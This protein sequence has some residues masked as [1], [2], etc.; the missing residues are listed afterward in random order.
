MIEYWQGSKYNPR[1]WQYEALPK[2]IE[3]LKNGQRPIVAATMGAGKSVVIAELCWVALH[4]LKQTQKIIIAAPRQHL[5]EQLADTVGKRIGHEKVG[6]FY[7]HA[8]E[9]SPPVIVCCYASAKKLSH[10]LD[11]FRCVLL[12]GDEVHGTESDHFKT[13]Y[14]NIAPLCSVGFTATP[15]RSETNKTLSLWDSIAY[16]YTAKEALE[17]GVIVPWKLVHWDGGTFNKNQVDEICLDLIS[18]NGVGPGIVN[19]SSI[20]DCEAFAD[21]LKKRGYKAESVH[22]GMTKDEQILYIDRLRLG[23]LDILVHVNMLSE[24]VDFPFL[25]WLCMRRP[26]GAKV[27]FVQEVGRVLRSDVGKTEAIIMDPFD[28]FSQHGLI[29]PEQIGKL[30]IN[31]PDDELLAKL[32]LE[33]NDEIVEEFKN[34][35]PAV[36]INNCESWITGMITTMRVNGLAKPPNPD[37][38]RLRNEPPT[39]RQIKTLSRLKWAT[40][41]LP[42]THRDDFKLFFEEE[43]LLRLSQGAVS[44][45]LDICFSLAALSTSQRK[46]HRHWNFPESVKLP[47]TKIPIQGLL[48]ITNR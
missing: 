3:C 9:I 36:A 5:V 12:I 25:R 26:V 21:L 23:Y 13:A 33:D 27:R 10:W 34:M 22:S 39:D 42:A 48:F 38:D 11:D 1:N 47:N 24:G 17:D 30:L 8:K 29:Y 28:L 15:F 32:D 43:R 19:A 44:D 37:F 4:K 7:S 14:D 20:K 18:K 45:M 46:S 2:I 41:Y 6:L 31:D 16:R 35:R 40:R